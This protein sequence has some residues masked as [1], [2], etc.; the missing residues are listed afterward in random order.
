MTL[1]DSV[2]PIHVLRTC[3]E[4]LALVTAEIAFLHAPEA[5]FSGCGT[6]NTFLMRY[7]RSWDAF[8][9]ANSRFK[10]SKTSIRNERFNESII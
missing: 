1:Y 7:S 10:R 2:F 6:L 8:K 4:V 5:S 3:D 9:E